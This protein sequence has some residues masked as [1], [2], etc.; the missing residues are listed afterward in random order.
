MTKEIRAAYQALYYCAKHAGIVALICESGGGKTVIRR[1]LDNTIR[2]RQ[3]PIRILAPLASTSGCSP[4][5]R[6][7][8]RSSAT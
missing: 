5:A 7:A 4:P 3:E 6:S 2:E 1:W 8:R